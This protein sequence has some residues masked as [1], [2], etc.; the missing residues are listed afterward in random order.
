MTRRTEFDAACPHCGQVNEVHAGADDAPQPG[1]VSICWT[2]GTPG[3]YTH[4]LAIRKPTQE[5]LIEI[6]AHPDFQKAVIARALSR[7]P[8]EAS[9]RVWDTP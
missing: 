4:D 9:R 3:V 5:E 7:T 2:C 1:D 6:A 8:G